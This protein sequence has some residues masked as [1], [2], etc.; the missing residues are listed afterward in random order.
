ML[1]VVSLLK[2]G[3]DAPSV[4]AVGLLNTIES[5]VKY[6]QLVGR[7]T[8]K[9]HKNDPVKAAVI[10]HNS[11]RDQL[12]EMHFNS[13]T[14]HSEPSNSKRRN[15]VHPFVPGW[16]RYR[17]IFIPLDTHFCPKFFRARGGPPQSPFSLF[18][19]LRG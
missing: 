4:S 2:E 7:T 5:P 11:S 3:F 13:S 18:G 16:V 9:L 8:R 10:C 12:T 1:L 19:T 6:A 15:P 17:P 14:K